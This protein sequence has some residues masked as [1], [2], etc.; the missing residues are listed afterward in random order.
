MK[1]ALV[2]VAVTWALLGW[3]GGAVASDRLQAPDSLTPATGRPA[4]FYR[5]TINN[6]SEICTRLGQ[7]LR[8]P[9]LA[10]A[11]PPGR[12]HFRE[13]LLGNEFSIAWTP[14]QGP[15]SPE[16]AMVDLNNDGRPE[17]LY[18]VVLS[19]SREFDVLIWADTAPAIE[20]EFPPERFREVRGRKLQA[21]WQEHWD[22]V[23]YLYAR[24][25]RNVP[26]DAKWDFRKL[27]FVDVA[28]V[29]G[30]P[31]LLAGSEAST[32]PTR[33]VA[34]QAHERRDQSIVC[35]FENYKASTD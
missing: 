13:L 18:R 34:L 27:V 25:I 28:M 10:S 1:A 3:T 33:V 30:T 12:E 16:R 35:L 9:R 8:A 7:A 22:G 2:I 29:N 26:A 23:V 5:L 21:P 17:V 20:T 31:I 4:D 19:L 32:N 15:K 11:K 14:L 24:T 6:H